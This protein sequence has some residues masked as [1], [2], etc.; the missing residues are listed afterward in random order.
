VYLSVLKKCRLLLVLLS[1]F[2]CSKAEADIEQIDSLQVLEEQIDSL[3]PK[4]LV[5]FDVDEVIF[6]D[7]D[8]ILKPVGD[9]LKFQIF[10]EKYA[11]AESRSEKDL[12][13]SILSLPLIKAK[14]VLVEKM[15]PELI[16]K[17]Q[18]KSI[19]VI[20][21]TSCP[22]RPFGIIKNFERWRLSHIEGFGIDFQKSFPKQKRFVFENITSYNVPPPVYNKGVIFAEGFSKADVLSAFLT[23]TNFKP[24]KVVFID[25]MYSNLQEMEEKLSISRIPYQGYYYIKV[26]REYSGNLDEDVARFQFDYLFKNQKWLSDKEAKKKMAQ[27]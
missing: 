12:T 4:T 13:T 10:N 14:K 7:E 21:L 16:D 22:T 17:L 23:K 3:D 5:V 18:K 8:A 19:K 26:S 24:S 27:N 25:D 20:A 6:M 11:K 15:T 9:P 2:F 1:A